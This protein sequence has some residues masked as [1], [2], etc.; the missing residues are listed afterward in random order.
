M[1]TSTITKSAAPAF[2]LVAWFLLPQTAHCFYNP[3]TGRWLSRDPL[4]DEAFLRSYSAGKDEM[5]QTLLR[6]ASMKPSY[7]FALNQPVSAIDLLGLDRWE[8]NWIHSWVIVEEWDR[9]C[10]KVIGYKRIE[11]TPRGGW[12]AVI[13]IGTGGFVG[14]GEVLITSTGKPSGWAPNHISSA[15]VADKFLLEW[16][17]SMAADPPW[18]S[19]WAFNCRT[20][21]AIAEM[22][23]IDETAP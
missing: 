12:G 6:S 23:G 22:M 8:V 9:K 7:V 5:G 19:F 13:L 17:Q 20:F 18:Y 4:G 16:A 15:C 10:C 3:T 21:A 11:F 14:P 2:L 1:K